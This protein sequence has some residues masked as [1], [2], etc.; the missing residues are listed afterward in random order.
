MV[1]VEVATVCGR[2]GVFGG[3]EGRDFEVEWCLQGGTLTL[4]D[5]MIITTGFLRARLRK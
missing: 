2:G 3:V 5:M 1:E 4:R